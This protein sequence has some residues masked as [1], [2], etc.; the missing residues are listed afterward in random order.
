MYLQA[1]TPAWITLEFNG[2]TMKI[3]NWPS[4]PEGSSVVFVN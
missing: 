4:V 2:N 3:P 1:E